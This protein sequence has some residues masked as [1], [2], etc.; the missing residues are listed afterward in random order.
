MMDE[1]L[2]NRPS[3]SHNLSSDKAL[4]LVRR[5]P[6]KH[7]GIRTNGISHVAHG[8]GPSAQIGPVQM[9]RCFSSKRDPALKKRCLT[10]VQ[11]RG[12]SEDI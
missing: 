1:S 9:H 11:H 4:G 7:P 12:P 6:C 10:P 2:V 5:G 3:P 8:V